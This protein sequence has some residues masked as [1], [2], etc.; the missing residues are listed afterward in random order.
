MTRL[1]LAALVSA[2]A[3][4]TPAFANDMLA[5]SLGVEPGVYSLNELTNLKTALEND[6]RKTAR[7]ILRTG[8]TA[9][10]TGELVIA[11]FSDKGLREITG[12]RAN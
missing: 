3:L 10:Q 5:R 12:Y 7:Q 6:D 9:A 1:L 11:G 8:G 2:A 4:T